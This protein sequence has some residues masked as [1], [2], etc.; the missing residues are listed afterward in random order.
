MGNAMDDFGTMLI[1]QG[2]PAKSLMHHDWLE[3]IMA[4]RRL[5]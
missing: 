3:L 5:P 2:C 1:S 4:R